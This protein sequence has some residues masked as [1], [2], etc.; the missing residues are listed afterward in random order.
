MAISREQ[1]K[2]ICTKPEFELV[3][4]SFPPT[5]LQ[6]TPARL[7]SKAER[8]RKLQDKYRDL[9]RGQSRKLKESNPS[10]RLQNSNQRT[11]QKAQLFGEVRD[12]FEEHLAQRSRASL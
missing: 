10:S 7:R 4:A 8:S 5:V 9:S 6:L 12:R 2:E 11:K 1:A 3:E